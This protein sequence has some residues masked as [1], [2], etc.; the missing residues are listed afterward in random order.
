MI[1]AN[2]FTALSTLVNGR[3]FPDVAPSATTLPYITFQQ[4]GGKPVNFL[5]AEYADKKNARFQINVWCATRIEA[6]TLSRSIE[7]LMVQSPL[8]GVIEGGSIATYDEETNTRGA[9]QDFS[10]WS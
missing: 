4:K 8:L 2:L 5:G 6:A 10:F 1:E 7:N 3:V 9:M